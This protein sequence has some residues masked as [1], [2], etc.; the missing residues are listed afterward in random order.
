M[1]H[2]DPIE[3]ARFLRQTANSYERQLW[4]LLRNR[5]R[6][7]MKC[8]RQHPMGIY[9]ADFYCAEAKLVVEIDRTSHFTERGRQYD[10]TRDRAMMEQGIRV[11]PLTPDLG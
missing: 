1:E 4:E 5:Q 11:L 6:C 2:M 9:T 10:A 8:R 3:F 7:K